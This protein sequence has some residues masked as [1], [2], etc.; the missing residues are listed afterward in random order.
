MRAS[1]TFSV[2]LAELLPENIDDSFM[3]LLEVHAHI[4]ASDGNEQYASDTTTPVSR[5]NVKISFSHNMKS[6]FKPGIS[7][8]GQVCFLFSIRLRP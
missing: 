4:V 5:Q 1:T 3:G 7:F 2:C 6:H 8:T